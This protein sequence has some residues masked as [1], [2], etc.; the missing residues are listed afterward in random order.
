M[1]AEATNK[2]DSWRKARLAMIF[3]TAQSSVAINIKNSPVPKV[4]CCQAP[5]KK[6]PTKSSPKAAHCILPKR[7]PKKGRAINA[8]QMNNVLCIKLAL[9]A[10]VILRQVK[11]KAKGKLPPT[12]PMATS[13]N[14]S[15]LVRAL[16]SRQRAVN[17][18]TD[19]NK[20]A[21]KPFFKK[22]SLNSYLIQFGKLLGQRV[23]SAAV[24]HIRAAGQLVNFKTSGQYL[25]HKPIALTNTTLIKINSLEHTPTNKKSPLQITLIQIYQLPRRVMSGTIRSPSTRAL[26]CTRSTSGC[27]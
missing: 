24:I 7:S 6:L 15:G 21:T 20:T 10:E 22:L 12:T 27:A 16:I 3:S 13:L 1:R 8:T 14:Q 18:K 5:K 17:I 9:T 26:L 19:N 4:S 25:L 11:N 23:S 2:L